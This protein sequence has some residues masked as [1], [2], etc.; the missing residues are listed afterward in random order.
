MASEYLNIPGNVKQMYLPFVLNPNNTINSK[1]IAY[2][3]DQSKS[4]D[5]VA[6]TADQKTQFFSFR[7]QDK[8]CERDAES[9]GFIAIAPNSFYNQTEIFNNDIANKMCF[10]GDLTRDALSYKSV[11]NSVPYISI[12]EYLQ[13]AKLNQLINLFSAFG[14][15]ISAAKDQSETDNGKFTLTGFGK[16][17][18]NF[19]QSITS[20]EIIQELISNAISYNIGQFD[21]MTDPID[22]SILKI[23]YIFYYR[24]MSA[25]STNVYEVPYNGKMILESQGGGFSKSG[26]GDLSTSENTFLGT[27][28]NWFGKNIRTNI[29]PTWDGPQ[30]T[31]TK[32]DI[33]FTLYN[34]DIKSAMKNFIFVNTIVPNNKWLQYHIFQH[35]P[36]LYDVRINGIGRLLMCQG[37]FKV[38]QKGVLRKPSKDFMNILCGSHLNVKIDFNHNPNSLKSYVATAYDTVRIP[39]IYDVHLTFTSLLPNNFNNYLFSYYANDKIQMLEGDKLH[40]ESYFN[41]VANSLGEDIKIIWNNSENNPVKKDTYDFVKYNS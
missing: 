29:T 1:P 27:M 12:R 16:H 9:S 35:A 4:K 19:I 28:I 11:L 33:D 8:I 25:T 10:A 39:D 21:D 30:D 37:D 34:D 7:P 14:N 2:E 38:E 32:I 20:T 23:P 18:W 24:L 22:K 31:P 5:T 3:S 40:Q 36:C 17:V 13:D 15:G 6:V 41:K 26:L